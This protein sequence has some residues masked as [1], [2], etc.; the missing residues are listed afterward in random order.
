MMKWKFCYKRES[1]M[2]R[3]ACTYRFI[4]SLLLISYGQAIVAGFIGETPIKIG[5][6]SSS[7]IPIE[8][9]TPGIRVACYDVPINQ[10]RMQRTVCLIKRTVHHYKRITIGTTVIDCSFEQL[11]YLPLE[12]IWKAAQ[13]LEVGDTLLT[14]SNTYVFIDTIQTIDEEI[15]LYELGVFEYHNFYVSNQEILVHNIAPVITLGFAGGVG[16]GIAFSGI[17]A[18]A[19]LGGL[20]LGGLAAALKSIIKR[21]P[22]ELPVEPPQQRPRLPMSSNAGN[23]D[24]D[25]RNSQRQYHE[26]QSPHPHGKY[27]AAV[28]HHR[29]SHGGTGKGAKNPAPI[30]GQA[31]LDNSVLIK[32]TSARRIGISNGQF[33]VLDRTLQGSNP[34]QDIYHGHVRTW[35]ELNDKM[36]EALKEAGLVN[37]KGKII[38]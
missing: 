23:P 24:E 32:G 36:Q 22:R 35:K 19:T 5:F 6:S 25:P 21:H 26:Q 14:H 33:V 4:A 3:N 7:T 11:F 16:N 9:V 31:A 12:Q 28:Y 34:S 18:M 13:F 38:R 30:D 15:D 2:K 8:Q 37:S 29:N 20:V 10:Q 27:V 1:S 17:T